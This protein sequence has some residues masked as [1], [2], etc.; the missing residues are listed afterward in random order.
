MM[1][2]PIL[3]KSARKLVLSNLTSTWQ[4]G[5]LALHTPDGDVVTLGSADSDDDRAEAYVHDDEL[6][7]RMLLRGEMG[8]GEAYVA[9]AWDAD[10]LVRVIR[11]FLR[12]LGKALVESPVTRLARLPDRLRHRM[13][14]NTHKGS[15]DNIHAHYDLGNDF[16]KLFLGPTWVYSCAYYNGH[17][18]NLEAAQHAKLDRLFDKIDLQE[19]D[20]LLDI[21]C[22]WGELAI[23]AAA[24]RGCKVTGI[25][26]SRA[27]LELAQRRAEQA[28]VADQVEFRFC[29]YRDLD[30]TFDKVTSVE[31]IE[32][33]GY[34]FLPDYFRSIA[35]RLKPGGKFGLQAITMPEA[36]F[37]R[38][39]KETDWMQT[40]IF[41]GSLIPSLASLFEQISAARMKVD[42]LFDIGVHYAPTLATWRE[43]Y[44]QNLPAVKQLGFDDRFDRTWTMYLA[45]SEAAFAERSLGDAQIIIQ[46]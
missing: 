5:Q 38:Y 12:N 8:A 10:N 22:G 17:G 39:R 44:K 31:M 32:A 40:Y 15:K 35:A 11:L 27:Q 18:D 28:G 45:F 33:V 3:T 41:P 25:T 4:H 16:Y 37:E 21:G 43:R 20:H 34:E 1:T 9:G 13:K 24:M 2:P 36:R 7:L 14:A 42:E 23:R 29:D 6:F 26:V 30:G 46:N 19:D